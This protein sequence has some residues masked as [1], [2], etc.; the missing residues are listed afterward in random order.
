M[1]D[2]YNFPYFSTSS[3][4]LLYWVE[5][6]LP[7]PPAGSSLDKYDGVVLTGSELKDSSLFDGPWVMEI[8]ADARSYSS[9]DKRSCI[10]TRADDVGWSIHSTGDNYGARLTHVRVVT[11]SSEAKVTVRYETKRKIL[12]LECQ[13]STLGFGPEVPASKY[14]THAQMRKM[15]SSWTN[16]REMLSYHDNMMILSA[17]SP[18][19]MDAY[20][21]HLARLV[22]QD[23]RCRQVGLKSFWDLVVEANVC[24]RGDVFNDIMSALGLTPVK[25]TNRTEIHNGLAFGT[26]TFADPIPFNRKGKCCAGG[27]YFT[28]A[29]YENMWYHYRKDD[30][31]VWRRVVMVP[32]DAK[33]VFEE[34]FKCKTNTIKVL[35]RVSICPIE[36]KV[37]E[38]TIMPVPFPSI[39]SSSSSPPNIL[40]SSPSPSSTSSS[41]QT[42]PPAAIIT[43]TTQSI[44]LSLP[45]NDW[46][47]HLDKPLE[48]GDSKR[49]SHHHPMINKLDA[50]DIQT[51]V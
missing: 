2:H 5:S 44:S 34:G 16:Y 21:L 42:M 26:G 20:Y 48:M 11:M 46:N 12:R 32:E 18:S 28:M 38:H 43:S 41:P 9:L 15:M 51:K 27:I 24:F 31:M 1:T 4:H 6:G 13:T 49:T 33:V 25:L 7:I 47:N 30:P 19:I 35:E 36:I 14:F 37:K 10:I 29:E 40:S 22:N 8:S 23:K 17:T 39:S 3:S 50:T 45:S